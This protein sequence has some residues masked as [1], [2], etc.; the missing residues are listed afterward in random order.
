MFARNT[1]TGNHQTPNR[2]LSGNHLIM[3]SPAPP[4]PYPQPL[5]HPPF[6]ISP[7]LSNIFGGFFFFFF[8]I[9]SSPPASCRT[10][11][12][13]VN[14]TECI[15]TREQISSVEN[16]KG[17]I[18]V[19]RCSIENQLSLY[20][21][22]GNSAILVLNRTSLNCNNALL[23][24][25]WRYMISIN[26]WNPMIWISDSTHERKDYFANCYSRTKLW[27]ADCVNQTRTHSERLTRSLRE[28]AG[29]CTKSM[30][31]S[32]SHMERVK[33]THNSLEE[34]HWS[35]CSVM[36]SCTHRYTQNTQTQTTQIQSTLPKSNSHK[37][38]N[39]LKL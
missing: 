10:A 35:T 4:P 12:Y 14:Q 18:A 20:K 38:N 24:L 3:N 1:T 36:H 34:V 6:P 39:T 21:V 33:N 28:P 29:P 13:F 5:P 22:Y 30:E 26:D 27:T 9:S 2:G 8:A 19:Q 17:I 11:L 32:E 15:F 37:S 23:A 31:V 16:Q 7:C 25:N